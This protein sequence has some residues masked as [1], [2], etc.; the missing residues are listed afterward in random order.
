M[1]TPMQPVKTPKERNQETWKRHR[2]EVFKQITLPL[3][4][5][6]SILGLISVLVILG[7]N[8]EISRWADISVI[9]LIIP[10]FFFT[11]LAMLILAGL[12]YLTVRIIVSLPFISYQI[13]LKFREVHAAI[14]MVSDRVTAPVIKAAGINASIRAAIFWPTKGKTSASR[15]SVSERK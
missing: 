14:R 4:I 3:I 1:N 12:V 8:M 9:W 5:G 13:L 11:F 2:Q 15:Q 7:S 10:A 6:G